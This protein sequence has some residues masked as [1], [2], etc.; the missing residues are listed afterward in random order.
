MSEAYVE[1]GIEKMN[2]TTDKQNNSKQS[3]DNDKDIHED[4]GTPECC[5]ECET[6]EIT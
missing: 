3:P 2:V 1:K 4:C 6:A 5:G